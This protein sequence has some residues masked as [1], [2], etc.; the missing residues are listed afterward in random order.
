MCGVFFFVVWFHGWALFVSQRRPGRCC[1]LGRER[2]WALLA[3]AAQRNETNSHVIT[4]LQADCEIQV[5]SARYCCTA[6]SMMT[7]R[8]RW[9]DAMLGLSTVIVVWEFSRSHLPQTTWLWAKEQ[10]AMEVGLHV[11]DRRWH[12][13][14]TGYLTVSRRTEVQIN[15]DHFIK[16]AER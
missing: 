12:W 16:C 8:S 11:T 15:V 6:L 4:E 13:M 9:C 7:I 5:N 10:E 1:L 2:S 3:G 14:P